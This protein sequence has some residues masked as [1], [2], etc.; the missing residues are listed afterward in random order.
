MPRR[1]ITAALAE[2]MRPPTEAEGRKSTWDTVVPGLMLRVTPTGKRT[3]AVWTRLR[4]KPLL[5]TIGRLE[6]F[7]LAKARETAR[8]VLR[9]V[10]DG[11]DPR[12]KRRATEAKGDLLFERVAADFVERYIK[13]EKK[14]RTASERERM[15]NHYLVERW[16]GRL[17]TEI[18]KRDVIELLDELMDQGF[19]A[20]A[21]RVFAAARKLF[22]WSLARDL[23]PASPCA[24]LAPPAPE[25]T[26]ERVLSD[27]EIAVVWSATRSSS[28]S[29]AFGCFVR[30]LFATGQ[31]RGEV[32]RMRWEDLD[33]KRRL[34]TLP[35]EFYK[36][37]RVHVVPLSSLAVEIL[38]ETPR[39]DKCAWVFSTDGS[40]PLSGFSKFKAKLDEETKGVGGWRFH[41]ARRTVATRMT[42]LGVPRFIVE[43][44]LGHADRTVTG[45]YDRNT[46]LPEKTD[47]LRR[48]S[49][50]LRAITKA[51]KTTSAAVRTSA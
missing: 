50:R 18:T 19:G 14:L 43:R 34:W 37:D 8:G 35:S 7:P 20:G 30:M 2:K 27:D 38:E 29:V 40:A 10:A 24:G 33:M 6:A 9:D 17:V 22:N 26:R 3:W 46:Y 25:T 21:N 31:R 45:I 51:K 5:Y 28:V 48:W 36:T 12:E 32:S 4:G 42:E 47:A 1:T 44:V 11:I 16:K 13:G 23:I 15:V 41:D 49:T 39:H